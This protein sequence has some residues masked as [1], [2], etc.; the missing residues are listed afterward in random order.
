MCGLPADFRWSANISLRK[1]VL[2][3]RDVADRPG[4]N[5][6]LNLPIIQELYSSI[7]PLLFKR[8]SPIILKIKR[9]QNMNVT[10]IDSDV[11]TMTENMIVRSFQ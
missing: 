1:G 3:L 6:P 5:I 10:I 9:R 8:K 7:S 2:E 11:Y 4:P